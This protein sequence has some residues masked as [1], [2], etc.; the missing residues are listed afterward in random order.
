MSITKP[1]TKKE[2]RQILGLLGYC[3][4]WIEG[5]TQAVKCLYEK[6]T[7][8][9][10]IWTKED[11]GRFE[12]LKQKL[13]TAPALSLPALE[14]PF[15]LFVNID[16]GV[17]HGVLTQDWGGSKKPVAYLCKL[18]D[19]VRRAWPTCIQAVATTSLL[20]EESRKLT[21]GGKL[22]VF[23]P[24]SVRSILNQKAEKLL[25]ASLIL[26]YEAILTD[27]NHLEWITNKYLNPAQFLYGELVRAYVCLDIIDYQTKVREDLTD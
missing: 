23:T 17:A 20:V 7:E 19:P 1:K 4:L 5:Y 25:T 3:W 10:V 18:L 12:K 27:R 2:L 8:E 9:E 22:N 21:F 15:Y 26:K 11:E 13:I 14:K 16:S 24:H 6:L